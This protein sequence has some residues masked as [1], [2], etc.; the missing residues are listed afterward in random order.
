[1]YDEI[2]CFDII[3]TNSKVA[4]Q[5]SQIHGKGLFTLVEL[6]KGEK[7]VDY[8]GKEMSLSNFKSVYGDYK[9]NS[10]F[11]YRMKRINK[12]LVAKEEPYITTNVINYTNESITPNCEL[13]KRALYA[14]TDISAGSELTLKYPADYFRDYSL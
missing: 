3:M 11:T 8:L 9:T 10:L 7:I 14:L 12:I 1:M 2:I 5:S 4:I 13:K 6:K